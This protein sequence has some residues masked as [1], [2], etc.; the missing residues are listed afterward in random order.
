MRHR[1]STLIGAFAA[2]SMLLIACG[3]GG[4]PPGPTAAPTSAGNVENGKTKFAGT[5][6]SCH[7]PEARG[8]QGL[9]KDLHNNAFIAPMSDAEVV[10]FLKKGRPA[11]DPLNTTKVDMPP[12][13]GNP[14][15]SDQDMLDIVAFLRT[16]K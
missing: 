7:G 9:G 1:L 14:A 10:E 16:L 13:G 11:T 15:L 12:K 3:G 4:S 6:T 2:A 5:C 8:M